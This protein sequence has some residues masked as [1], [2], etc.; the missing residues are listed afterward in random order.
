VIAINTAMRAE[1]QGIGFAIPIDTAKAIKD[2]LARGEKIAH[3]YL[4][5]RMLTLTP[6]VAKQLN[7][8]PNTPFQAP[9]IAGVLVVQVLPNSPAAKAGLRLGDAIVEVDGQAV[10]TADRLQDLVAKSRIGQPLQFKVQ[11]DRQI[12]RLSVRPSE[13]KDVPQD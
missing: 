5:I 8:D 2:R 10:T 12:E 7:N 11:R 13:L 6:A 1:A 4:G 3:P 9:E